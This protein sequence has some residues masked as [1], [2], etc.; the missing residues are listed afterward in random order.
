[1]SS[2]VMLR[3]VVLLRTDVSE[4]LSASIIG[5]TR[6]GEL[7][8]TLAVTSNRRTLSLSFSETWVLTRDTR[9]NIPEDAILRVTTCYRLRRPGRLDM[10]GYIVMAHAVTVSGPSDAQSLLRTFAESSF[11]LS[12]LLHTPPSVF[13]PRLTFMTSVA[14]VNH[15]THL[16]TSPHLPSYFQP[17]LSHFSFLLHP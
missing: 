5:V 13:S 4:E 2:Y 11:T 12:H 1:M 6:I 8:T 3:R 16:L 15:R 9:R 17:C 7:G 14:H 10:Y